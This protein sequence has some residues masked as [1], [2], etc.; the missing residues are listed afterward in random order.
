LS[1]RLPISGGL[2]LSQGELRREHFD[3]F[4]RRLEICHEFAIPTMLLFA[5]FAPG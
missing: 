2:L 1:W 3:H 5:D 4:S